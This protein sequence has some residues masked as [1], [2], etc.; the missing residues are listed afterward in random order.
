M[1][2]NGHSSPTTLRAAG[3]RRSAGFTLV[4]LTVAMAIVALLAMV[5]M[6]TFMGQVRKSRRSDAV[7][8]IVRMQQAQERWRANNTA[9]AATVATL[10]AVEA[11]L[12]S[13]SEKAY[14]TLATAPATGAAATGY[15]VTASAASGTSQ[16]SDTAC[17]TLTATIAGGTATYAPAGCWSK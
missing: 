16:S 8:A 1:G 3:S 14:Y 11:G 15:S 12:T 17:I 6:P 5:A 9:Y 4:E 10:T 7:A 2:C 13:S